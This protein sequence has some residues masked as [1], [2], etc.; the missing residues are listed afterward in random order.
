M[1]QLHRNESQYIEWDQPRRE[2]LNRNVSQYIECDQPQ[3]EQFIHAPNHMNHSY[4]VFNRMHE[5]DA[6][7][8]QA[9]FPANYI[10]SYI[11]FPHAPFAT[12][13]PKNI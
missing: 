2:Q 12:S 9:Q 11:P 7:L 8:T 6:H 5:Y 3:R 10:P 13:H 1:E 4:H